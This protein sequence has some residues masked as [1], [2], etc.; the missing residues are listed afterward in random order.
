MVVVAP[1]RV[2]NR[3]LPHPFASVTPNRPRP[4]RGAAIH[5]LADLVAM[6]DD[7][8]LKVLQDLSVPTR[9]RMKMGRAL[10]P[11]R[12]ASHA[13]VPS[14]TQLPHEEGERGHAEPEVAH[15]AR[16]R[17]RAVR[18]VFRGTEELG[19]QCAGSRGGIVFR[20]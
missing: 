19:A 10:G 12:R 20:G 4:P 14:Q 5:T 13:G 8:L 9:A 3:V 2:P 11:Y 1:D 15:E 7:E 16:P 17:A 18:I 6:H